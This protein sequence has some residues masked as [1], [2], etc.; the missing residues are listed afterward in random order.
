MWIMYV[1]IGLMLVVEIAILCF[2]NVSRTVPTNYICLLIFTLCMSYLVS[3]ICSQIGQHDRAGQKIV[4][5]A[6]SMTLGI[7]VALTLYA[8]TTKT[9]FTMM[10][11]FLFCFSMIMMIFGI[12][13]CFS[14]SKIA[15][16]VYCALGCLMYSLYLI[17]DT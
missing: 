9:D 10:G 12:F 16:I 13:L 8:F 3:A 6:A 15:H 1:A 7:V 5:I 4:F 14:Y 11:G 17:Y 2:R